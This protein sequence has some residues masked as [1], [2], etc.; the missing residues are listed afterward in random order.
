MTSVC[1]PEALCLCS[2]SRSDMP[3]P[4]FQSISDLWGYTFSKKLHIDPTGRKAL[5]TEPPMN[6]RA[7]R[8]CMCQ[9]MFEEYVRCHS[10]GRC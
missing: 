4:T 8:Q 5:L 7:N 3:A 1:L 9:I 6:P 2:L 10:G